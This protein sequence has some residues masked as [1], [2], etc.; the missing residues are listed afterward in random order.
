MSDML[1]G[2]PQ[3]SVPLCTCLAIQPTCYI[4]TRVLSLKTAIFG[5]AAL[6]VQIHILLASFWPESL[7]LDILTQLPNA[8][9]IAH[10]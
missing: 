10:D 4:I 5:P 8:I 7:V 2:H 9:S 1:L 6:N 3:P